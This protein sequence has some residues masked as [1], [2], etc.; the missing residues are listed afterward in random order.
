MQLI[1][2]NITSLYEQIAAQLR[3]R[4]LSGQY[5]PTG[6]LPS[7]AELCSLFRVSRVTVRQALGKLTDEGVVERK[8]GKGT[9][10][11][12]KKVR[13][14]LDSLRSFHE[15][16][17]LQGL[18]PEMRLISKEVVPLPES[19]RPLFGAR[20]KKCLLLERLHL[21]DNEPIAF[22]RSHLP[23]KLKAVSW[24]DAQRQPNYTMLKAVT[25]NSV[26]RADIAIRAQPADKQ[27]A[28]LL[29]VKIGAA[30]MVMV[31]TSYFATDVCCDQSTFFIRPERYEFI[32]KST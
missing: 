18:K 24:N 10:A 28:Q 3:S 17:V 21:V 25:G 9:Y 29:K 30:L 19:L 7:E 14:G 4:I 5:D 20:L 22:G 8:Q 16:L 32:L 13:H 26:A 23:A 31:R 15:S 1:R 2:E 11:S 12:G 27:M 6:K